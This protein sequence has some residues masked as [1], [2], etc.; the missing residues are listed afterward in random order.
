[1]AKRIPTENDLT[2]AQ[3]RLYTMLPEE[4]RQ[5]FLEMLPKVSDGPGD[6]QKKVT[7]LSGRLET[8]KVVIDHLQNLQAELEGLIR[9]VNENGKV[10][11]RK[12]GN[13]PEIPGVTIHWK[14]PARAPKGQN[15]SQPEGEASGEQ[16]QSPRRSRRQREEVAA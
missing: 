16:E 2:P 15:G 12:E 13:L 1:M 11:L 6:K 7:V 10:D 4:D 3:A 9:S 14:M 5:E 8:V